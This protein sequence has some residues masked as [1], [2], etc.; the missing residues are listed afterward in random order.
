[1]IPHLP[2]I[3]AL[4]LSAVEARVKLFSQLESA[5]LKMRLMDSC[6]RWRNP[7]KVRLAREVEHVTACLE[8]V[9]TNLH[10]RE[11]LTKNSQLQTCTRQISPVVPALLVSPKMPNASR[12]GQGL[13]DLASASEF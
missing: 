3:P 4:D 11:A 13:H 7:R 9:E 12:E 1:M 6:A 5:Y 10:S 8:N 2:S